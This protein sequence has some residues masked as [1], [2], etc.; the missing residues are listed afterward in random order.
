MRKHFHG[1]CLNCLLGRKASGRTS[2]CKLKWDCL[3]ELEPAPARFS[4]HECAAP[5]LDLPIRYNRCPD[6]RSEGEPAN[7]GEVVKPGLI[8]Q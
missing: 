3:G 4:T 2:A 8:E 1:R 5:R 6:R 7:I